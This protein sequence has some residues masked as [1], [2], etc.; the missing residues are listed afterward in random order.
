MSESSAEPLRGT[1]DL[2]LL[3]A[4]ALGPM[5]GWGI[6]LRIQR[7]PTACSRSIRDRSIPRSSDW[8]RKNGST[9]TGSSPTTIAA[10]NTIVSRR[11]ATR[12]RR[13]DRELE[14]AR[15][16]GRATARGHL[17]M[18]TQTT[19]D[20]PSLAD[21][22]RR[23]KQSSTRRCVF[24]SICRPTCTRVAV[25]RPTRRDGARVSRSAA[26]KQHKEAMREGRGVRGIERAAFDVR[27]ALRQLRKTPGFTIAAVLT[28]ALGIGGN[29]AV[30]SVVNG[31]LLRPL[32]YP[33]AD[34]I[35]SIGHR[36]R[37]GELPARLPNSSA[38]HVVYS[39][40]KSSFDA[41]A[42][43]SCGREVLVGDNAPARV[44]RRR[45]R[46]AQLV[47]RAPRSAVARTHVHSR[48]RPTRRAE[49]RRHQRR[50]VA[51]AIRRRPVV[52]RTHHHAR[53]NRATVIGVMP[54][55]SRFRRPPHN[56]GCRCA[57]IAPTS[58]D[59]FFRGSGGS[60]TA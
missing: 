42:L 54:A 40:R 51:T 20:V 41:M 26:W 43:Y 56:S 21:V 33:R 7:P 3:R 55:G 49:R 22:A 58:A 59:S 48:G 34:R 5:H 52:R 24:T 28:L 46:D 57:S 10:R 17:I 1:I 23:S 9:A 35:V 18:R 45:H 30:F 53:R 32:A 6:T 4:L 31:V 19:V 11:P 44:G 60:A 50:A 12:A 2:L 39:G 27:F 8:S 25:C 13:R 29:T 36:T 15:R 37:G 14:E 47:R 38:T 16:G